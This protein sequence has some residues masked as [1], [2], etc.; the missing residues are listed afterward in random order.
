M[1]GASSFYRKASEARSGMQQKI[2]ASHLGEFSNRGSLTPILHM[3]FPR[4][5]L[6]SSSAASLLLFLLF[7][8][9]LPTS[10][11]TPVQSPTS[12]PISLPTPLPS[13]L[14]YPYSSNKTTTRRLGCRWD[15]YRKRCA[16]SGS[17]TSSSSS[18][19]PSAAAALRLQRQRLEQDS[20]PE[21]LARMALATQPPRSAS[22]L[23]SDAHD[24]IQSPQPP[25]KVAILYHGHYDRAGTRFSGNQCSDF[26]NNDFANHHEMLLR[27]LR[28][29]GSA[30]GSMESGSSVSIFFHTYRHAGGC[31]DKDDF[32]VK[33]LH[34]VAYEFGVPSSSSSSSSSTSKSS[35]TEEKLLPRR[36]D[37]YIRVLRLALRSL[38]EIHDRFARRERRRVTASSEG[39][40]TSPLLRYRP[41][42]KRRLSPALVTK[43]S[44]RLAKQKREQ[45]QRQHQLERQQRARGVGGG[46][47]SSAQYLSS[48]AFVLTRFDVLFTWPI[49]HPQLSIDWAAVSNGLFY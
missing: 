31:R 39:N 44:V 37:S 6:L 46:A 28:G 38:K 10:A 45:Q 8:S 16:S 7:S 26:L 11:P 23:P 41:E 22:Y 48:V 20:L 25:S 36:V 18:S 34:P 32:L 14:L 27:P 15:T 13:P 1:S 19:S 30:R 43:T 12:T 9:S 17:S 40:M 24:A 5:H 47:S 29:G 3:G 21:V 4:S 2:R 35:S 42:R 33:L 49:T